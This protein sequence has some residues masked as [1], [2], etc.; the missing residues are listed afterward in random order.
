MDLFHSLL[1]SIESQSTLT[2]AHVPDGSEAFYLAEIYNKHP[3]SLL[4]IA[5]DDIKLNEFESC[6]SFYSPH[7]PLYTLPAWDT[8]PYDRVSPNRNL[9]AKR[10]NC[11]TD[12][13]NH[14]THH[15]PVVLGISLTSLLQKIPHQEYFL[16]RNLI[17]KEQEDISFSTLQEF[18]KKEGFRRVDTVHETGEFSIRGSLI[19]IFPASLDL[20]VRLDFFGDTLQKIRSFDPLS[21]KSLDSLD[22]SIK[23]SPT[24]EIRLD[25]SSITHFR[26]QYRS[27][28]GAESMQDPLYTTLS[29]G[30]SFE[31]YE[32]WLPLFFETLTGPWEYL[33]NPLIVFSF[34]TE[35]SLQSRTNQIQDHYETRLK[36]L[37]IQKK[38]SKKA[39]SL[40]TQDVYRPLPPASLFW[41]NSSLFKELKPYK[42]LYLTPFSHSSSDSKTV[43][44]MQ[45]KKGE[46]WTSLRAQI[47]AGAIPQTTLF[48]TVIKVLQND[49][50]ESIP[51]LLIGY[52]PSSLHRL[53]HIFLEH[54][55]PTFQEIKK[56]PKQI[57][58]VLYSSILP[59]THGFELP[60]L[61]IHTEH[62]ILGERLVRPIFKK[63]KGT[64]TLF[65]ELGSFSTGDLLVHIQ[66]GVGKY[67]GLITLDINGAKHDCLSLTYANT[68]KLFVPVENM[69]VLSRFGS[70]DS[71]VILDKLGSTAWQ[72]RKARV[73]KRLKEIAEKLMTIAAQ[74]VLIEAPSF[75]YT[76]NTYEEFSAT[77]P[78]TETEDQCR[79][80]E[81]VLSDL[82]ESKP[83]DRLICGDVGFGKTEVALRAAFVVAKEG[84]QVALLAPTTLLVRQHYHTFMERFKDFGLQVVAL[85]R[86]NAAKESFLIKK[87]I[88]E[89]KAS[90]IIATHALFS[91]S[92]SFKD[93]GLLIID[94]EQH[95]G[96]SQKDK[97]K[98]LYPH[99][100][101]LTLTATP[102][103]R[104][105]Q[106]ALSGVRDLSLVTTPPIDR[107]AVRTF[108]LPYDRLIIREALM[109]EHYRGG[110]SFYVAPRIE[111]LPSLKTELQELV[112]DLKIGVAHG[113]LTASQLE[114]VMTDFYDKKY[115]ILLSTNIVES[116]LDIPS[117]N[118]LIIHKA[119]R[120]GLAQLYQLRGRV[121][122]SK[123]RGYAYFTTPPG[124]ILSENALKRLHVLETLDT[125]GV[126]FNVATHDMDIRGTGNLVGEEQSGHIK[127][128]GIELYQHML[129]EAIDAL[130]F[131]KTSLEV[132]EDLSPVQIIWDGPV[133]IPEDYIADLSLRLSLYR[134]LSRLAS[135]EE[136]DA[137]GTELIDRFGPYPSEI[138]NLLNIVYLKRLAEKVGISKVEVGSKGTLF[139]FAHN[140][141]K[142]PE[143]LV[144]LIT[145]SK[146]L[147]RLRPD[148]K[149]VSLKP[150]TSADQKFSHIEKLLLQL[151]SL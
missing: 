94:E 101:I 120:F 150:F 80:I 25:A 50:K 110:Q 59:I 6:F 52:S 147:L 139:S 117:A 14:H 57:S 91:K 53:T 145:A 105:L 93:L 64:D 34:Q 89:G 138:T 121:G 60:F 99:V 10:A 74:R 3:N 122:R 87:E 134:R 30:R 149:L 65:E 84:K 41:D 78:Y 103:P 127:E 133:L 11:L 70:E 36:N 19:D 112:P 79:A 113:Q 124:K 56:F 9:L 102:I 22:T 114:A 18:L 37:E 90:I 39:S 77:F 21:Q 32:H 104:T 88:S 75:S 123:V 33:Q 148:H 111:D 17:L 146:G 140:T 129:K 82:K 107:L 128:V 2:L 12:L 48:D 95:F 28:F 108:V 38:N 40:F 69:E 47:K 143:G 116:G 142:N 68:D 44:D 4:Y 72:A 8:T 58:S 1:T 137:F 119:D 141:F 125:L 135:K 62:D 86:F 130:K 51:T 76:E 81:D 98:E 13:A 54:E 67:E 126:G 27:F 66:H 136:I 109:R 61:K 20:P 97:L 131:K 5:R 35:E 73:K 115:N 42:K 132:E 100:H 144:K 31:G 15:K 55:G 45:G 16:R 24:H 85:S 63:K 29:E 83:M 96:V 7:I 106:L 49:L 151:G 71:S 46:D 23:L 118:T 92:L 26:T 43:F